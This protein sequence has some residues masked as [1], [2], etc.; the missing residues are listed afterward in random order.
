MRNAI[1]I[2]IGVLSVTTAAYMWVAT[3]HWYETVPGVN[4]SGPINFHF[5]K[6]V[7]LAYLASGI[8]LIWAGVRHDPPAAICGAAWPALHALFH[9][10]IWFHRGTPLDL[11]ALTNLMGIQTP[12]IAGLLA[13]LKLNAERS[14]A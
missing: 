10:A 5:A 13:A 3:L 4:L 7:A 12:A 14:K 8:A 2:G 1:L 11:V 6:D 9:I